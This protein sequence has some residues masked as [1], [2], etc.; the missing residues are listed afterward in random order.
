MVCFF[1][2]REVT[3]V[4]DDV[5][6][7]MSPLLKL[8]LVA[9]VALLRTMN[10][11]AEARLR[12]DSDTSPLSSPS[13]SSPSPSPSPSPSSSPSPS[14][15]SSSSSSL[16]LSSPLLHL[17]TDGRRRMMAGVEANLLFLL[18]LTKI[19]KPLDAAHVP[20][21]LQK[22]YARQ[23][24]S[25]TVDIARRGIHVRSANTVRSFSHVGE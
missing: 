3:S 2:F 10:A 19:P 16:S 22:L 24:R 17:T 18:G 14:P 21:S 20:E 9:A 6:M 7:R 25:G 8:M 23:N 1:F 11:N 12:I 13:P 4:S 15:S 5:T